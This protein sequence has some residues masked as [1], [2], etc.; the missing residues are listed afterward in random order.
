MQ[1]IQD[2]LLRFKLCASL[3]LVPVASVMLFA[4]EKTSEA[5]D[6]TPAITAKIVE[7]RDYTE[8]FVVLAKQALSNNPSDLQRAQIL[9]GTAYS[10]YAGWVQY[11]KT[12]LQKGKA[13]NLPKDKNYEKVAAEATAAATD[14]TTFVNTKTGQSKAVTA[15]LS[16]LADLGLKLWN[17]IKDR[18]DK[19]RNNSADAFEKD[20][21][22]RPWQDIGASPSTP[23]KP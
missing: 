4:A 2:N 5:Q 6:E 11:V 9:Y 8:S 17:G 7:A 3:L 22:W 19:D 10:K 12:S 18:I 13:K 21:K 1:L 23:A 15:I 16:S 14:F 20:A